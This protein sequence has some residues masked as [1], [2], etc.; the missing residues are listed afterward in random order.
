MTSNT[1]KA[2]D[3]V[4]ID[5]ALKWCMWECELIINFLMLGFINYSSIIAVIFSILFLIFVNII[6]K[7]HFVLLYLVFN[8]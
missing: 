6:T 8:E 1:I 7:K 2:Y 4:I 5:Y 3:H